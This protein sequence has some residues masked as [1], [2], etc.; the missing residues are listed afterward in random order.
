VFSVRTVLFY[1]EKYIANLQV[2]G[3]VKTKMQIEKQLILCSILAV[4]IGIATVAPL[5]LLMSPVK[6]QTDND[7]QPKLTFAMQYAYVRDVWN[8]S[9]LTSDT[10]GWAFKLSFKTSPTFNLTDDSV[11]YYETYRA[12]LASEKGSIGNMTLSALATSNIGL[13]N[14][15]TVYIDQWYNYT[16]DD[17]GGAGRSGWYNGTTINTKVG[18]GE[19]WDLTSGEPQTLTITVYRQNWIIRTINTTEIHN[20]NPEPILQIPLQRYRNGF[21]YNTAIP[22]D[23]LDKINPFFP[24]LKMDR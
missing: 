18:C 8:S 6:A 17:K 9:T 15:F 3:V 13:N 2:T 14:N 12:E 20:G 22:Q 4:A 10:Y 7:N 1:R 21:I 19:N 16:N 5:A 24:E 11:A 23:E